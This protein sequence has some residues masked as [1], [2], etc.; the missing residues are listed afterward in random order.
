ML[1]HPLGLA[2]QLLP[3]R[4]VDRHRALS[5]ATSA[6]RARTAARW[7]PSSSPREPFVPEDRLGFAEVPQDVAVPLEEAARSKV[8]SA[9]R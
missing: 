2:R 9:L 3:D 1:E 4:V 8:S 7:T 5:T 6:R